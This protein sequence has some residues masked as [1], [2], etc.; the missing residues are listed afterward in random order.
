[1][2]VVL[3]LS[4]VAFKA[5]GDTHLLKNVHKME[6]DSCGK[7]VQ[8]AVSKLL[9]CLMLSQAS[10]VAKMVSSRNYT[11]AAFCLLTAFLTLWFYCLCRK[12]LLRAE[13]FDR[14]ENDGER[15]ERD[16]RQP[17][18][19]LNRYCHPIASVP[20]LKEVL[21]HSFANYLTIPHGKNLL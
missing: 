10:I 19:F 2:L 3:L 13:D 17:A 18:E 20:S 5:F 4:L 1:M 14:G 16:E 21:A 8:N 6:T 9:L 12:P 15:S 7:I 11:L